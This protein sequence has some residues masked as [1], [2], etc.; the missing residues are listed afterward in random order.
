MTICERPSFL[1]R[2]GRLLRREEKL[3]AQEDLKPPRQLFRKL[4]PTKPIDPIEYG[5]VW[6]EVAKDIEDIVN[7][8]RSN[9]V[10]K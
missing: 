6:E 9:I 10:T 1:S 3:P 4:D 7:T 8:P 2:L 5:R